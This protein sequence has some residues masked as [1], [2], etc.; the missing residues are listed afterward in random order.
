MIGPFKTEPPPIP[1]SEIPETSKTL[2]EKVLLKS[3]AEKD[4]ISEIKSNEEI[5][6]IKSKFANQCSLCPMSFKKPSDLTRHFRTHTGTDFRLDDT[7]T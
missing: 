6:R 2:S 1:N 7:M 5:V 4:R 3:M